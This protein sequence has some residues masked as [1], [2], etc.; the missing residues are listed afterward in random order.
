MAGQNPSGQ[1]ISWCNWTFSQASE[2]SAA[3]NTG[4]CDNQ[5]WNN[6]S[7]SGTWVKDHILNPTDDFGPPTPSI[8]ITS[9]ANNTTVNIGSNLVINAS[10]NNG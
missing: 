4:A 3:L 10:G 8:T 2:S 6:T 5:Q 9:P 7:T 1:K